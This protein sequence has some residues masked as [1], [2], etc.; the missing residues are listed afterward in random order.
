MYAFLK[1]II[2]A[3]VVTLLILMASIKS[4][5]WLRWFYDILGKENSGL[6]DIRF[7]I[8]SV[9]FTFL[10]SWLLSLLT[11]IHASHK[12]FLGYMTLS[13]ISLLLFGFSHSFLGMNVGVVVMNFAILMF[14]SSLLSVLI[15]FRLIGVGSNE[16][17]DERSIAETFE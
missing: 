13:W 2:F 15:D 3:V 17:E 7:V 11:T 6:S 12:H 9:T 10:C 8:I 16:K 4:L 14:A 1:R 5:G